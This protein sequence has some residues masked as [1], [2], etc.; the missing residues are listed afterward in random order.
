MAYIITLS[1]GLPGDEFT[2]VDGGANDTSNTSLT[3]LA[4][5]ATNFGEIAAENIVHITENFA[6]LTDPAN[7]LKGQLWFASDSAPRATPGGT[8]RVYNGFEWASITTT[9]V[10]VSAP[11]YSQSGDLWH[12]LSANSTS[13]RVSGVWVKLLQESDLGDLGPISTSSLTVTGSASVEENLFVGGTFT[14]SG[15][16]SFED[17]TFENIFVGG[18]VSVSG[19]VS[20]SGDVTF[21]GFTHGS[22]SYGLV[23]T[24]SGLGTG[25]SMTSQYNI[26]ITT[27]SGTGVVLPNSVIG[28]EITVWNRDGATELLIYPPTADD[29]IDALLSGE[30]YPLGAEASQ[31]F[32]CVTS[33]IWLSKPSI[34]S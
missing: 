3:L 20:I 14:V 18:D 8:I 31:D 9:T 22:V 25:L 5:G 11:D 19:D 32:V 6:N 24:G 27:G 4:R 1:N 30:A 10:A 23:S 21:Y 26:V 7:P 16:S 17:A 15:N 12:D 2:I 34:Y 29:V 33:A 13:I 28:R